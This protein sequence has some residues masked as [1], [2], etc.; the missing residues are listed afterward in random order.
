MQVAGEQAGSHRQ[1]EGSGAVH[2]LEKGTEDP[3][4]PLCD[5]VAERFGDHAHHRPCGGDNW[6]CTVLAAPAQ[7]VAT[8]SGKQSF[9]STRKSAESRFRRFSH[10]TRGGGLQGW[11]QGQGRQQRAK[12]RVVE[13][14]ARVVIVALFGPRCQATH[15]QA[16]LAEHGS[17]FNGVESIPKV[18]LQKSTPLHG[19]CCAMAKALAFE[20]APRVGWR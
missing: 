4:C 14:Q 15:V 16:H 11:L 20:A 10:C 1:V 8:R 17:S 12:G 18:H 6:L 3:A 2:P 19:Q 7:P 13:E 5:R 9:T